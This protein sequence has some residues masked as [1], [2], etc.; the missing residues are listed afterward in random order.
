M[1]A[2]FVRHRLA[3]RP[4]SGALASL[5]ERLE[6]DSPLARV[7]RAWPMLA[8]ALPVASEGE[9]A[10][11]RDGVLTVGCSASVY[12]SELHFLAGDLVV[13]LNGLLGE[14]LVRTLRMRTR[15]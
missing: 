15:G 2:T 12:A 6:P 4:L 3:P 1:T 9:P 7:Q 13:A 10:T 8:D 11:L 14:E 5:T